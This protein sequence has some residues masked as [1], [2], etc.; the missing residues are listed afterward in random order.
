MKRAIIPVRSSANNCLS[1]RAFRYSHTVYQK[2]IFGTTEGGRRSRQG[3]CNRQTGRQAERGCSQIVISTSA[4]RRI[5]TWRELLR[6]FSNLLLPT[7]AFSTFSLSLFASL[8]PGRGV[9]QAWLLANLFPCCLSLAPSRLLLL[10]SPSAVLLRAVVPWTCDR[11][12]ASE[13]RIKAALTQSMFFS[14]LSTA[15]CRVLYCRVIYTRGSRIVHEADVWKEM[16]KN[17][18]TRVNGV[19]GRTLR[20]PNF[21]CDISPERSRE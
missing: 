10:R 18:I 16:R 21:R 7:P 4:G 5:S 13:K 11:R 9:Q 8:S 15:R 2:K 20:A 14:P 1:N 3:I 6:W 12:R 17:K 19:L